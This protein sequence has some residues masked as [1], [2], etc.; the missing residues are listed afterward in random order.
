MLRA[1]YRRLGGASDLD[2]FGNR[3]DLPAGDEVDLRGRWNLG[4]L[5][6]STISVTMA[7]DNLANALIIPQLGLPSPGRA[8]RIGLSID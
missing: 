8:L 3:A 5:G 6:D 1:E 2:P 7:A 4:K